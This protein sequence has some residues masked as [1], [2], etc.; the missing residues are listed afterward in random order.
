MKILFFYPENPLLLSQGNHARALALLHYFK[1]RNIEVDFVSEEFDD[2]KTLICNQKM[3]EE[4]LISN[5][6]FIRKFIKKK[7]PLGYFFTCSLPNKLFGRAKQFNRV[8]MGQQDD[9][10]NILKNNSYDYIIISYACW[11]PLIQ[12]NPYLKNAKLIVDTHDF[13]TAQFKDV[14]GFS[15]GKFFETEIQLLELFDTVVVISNE[16]KYLFSQF[17]KKD[18]A[19]I[20]HPLPNKFL[21]SNETKEFDIIYLGSNNA[22]NITGAKWFFEKVYPLLPNTV[23][24]LV[25]GGVTA[26]IDDYPNVTK[27]KFA[28]NLDTYYANA[29]MAVCPIFSGTGLKIKVIEALSYGLPIVCTEKG[30]DGM[31]NK[32][33]NGCLVTDDAVQFAAN[34]EKLL[35]DKAYYDSTAAASKRY[36]LKNNDSAAVYKNMDALFNQSTY[37]GN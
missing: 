32:T 20:T 14:K 11:A 28:E 12:N 31:N 16:E 29:K 3:C 22:H 27:I 23:K 34:I 8:R 19:L 4:K 5:Q 17:T 1:D 33:D 35:S 9:F 30:I 26:S 6:Y 7:H 10:N 2:P 18:V 24:I 37:N 25:I 13:L 15:L 36:F 21:N